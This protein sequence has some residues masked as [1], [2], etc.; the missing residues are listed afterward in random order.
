M[1]ITARNTCQLGTWKGSKSFQKKQAL[2][3]FPV[4]DDCGH[5]AQN[6]SAS[7]LEHLTRVQGCCC[8]QELAFGPL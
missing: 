1:R 7:L 3:S 5:R 6:S 8:Q 4:G 2:V